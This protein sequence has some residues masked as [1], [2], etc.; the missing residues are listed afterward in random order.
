MDKTVTKVEIAYKNI[1]VKKM[2]DNLLFIFND[3][4]QFYPL[5]LSG[6]KNND[7]KDLILNKILKDK[8]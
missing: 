3:K 5:K 8:K 6:F 7:D 1:K 2:N 4:N